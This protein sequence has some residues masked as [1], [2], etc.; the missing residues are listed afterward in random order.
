MLRIVFKSTLDGLKRTNESDLKS[1]KFLQKRLDVYDRAHPV[2]QLEFLAELKAAYLEGK[3]R[4]NPKARQMNQQRIDAAF[5]AFETFNVTARE[6][7][8]AL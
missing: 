6:A 7:L 4:L 2:D 8:S 5:K 3:G 1:V